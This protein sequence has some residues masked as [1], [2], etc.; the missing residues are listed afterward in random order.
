MCR[1]VAYLGPPVTLESLLLSPAHSLLRQAHAPRFQRHGTVN[2]DGFGVGWYDLARRPEPAVYRSTRPIWG[3]RSFG[4]LAGLVAS[5]AVLA[6]LRDATPPAVAEESGTPPFGD[7]PWLF[8]HNG[9]VD[10]FAE[11]GDGIGGTLRRRLSDRRLG[12]LQGATDSEV[13]FG[14]ILDRIDAGACPGEAMVSVIDT[15]E[16]LSGGRMNMV[17]TDGTRVTAT[18][19]GDSL[20]T[21]Q[22]GP[23]GAETR[24]IASEPFDDTPAWRPVPDRSVVEAGPEGIQVVP[25]ERVR[26]HT[27]QTR[28]TWTNNERR[29][30]ARAADQEWNQPRGQ[31][32]D[33]HQQQGGAA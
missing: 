25:M 8:A 21:L 6:V 24:I 28:G 15:V 14:L 2:A 18:S 11:A 1:F 5:A 20:Y 12:G 9:A 31:T 29:P 30:A 17:L 19:W 22:H 26:D 27:E 10:G 33:T 13:L 7:G 4:S 16:E 3:D 23:P 32:D